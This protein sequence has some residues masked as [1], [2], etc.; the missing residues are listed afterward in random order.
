VNIYASSVKR[1][2]CFEKITQ[3]FDEYEEENDSFFYGDATAYE[4][5][6]DEELRKVAEGYYDNYI[7]DYDMDTV[8]SQTLLI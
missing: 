4:Q 3:Q 1:L 8:Q 7:A 5:H 6:L 2:S